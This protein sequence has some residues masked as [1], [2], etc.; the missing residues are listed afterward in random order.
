MQFME[1][2]FFVRRT[3]LNESLFIS[4]PW[5]WRLGAVHYREAKGRRISAC[6]PRGGSICPGLLSRLANTP[7][8]SGW[9]SQRRLLRKEFR[10][11]QFHDLCLASSQTKSRVSTLFQLGLPVGTDLSYR[12][13]GRGGSKWQS[14]RKGPKSASF[15]SSYRQ[16]QEYDLRSTFSS[17]HLW[18]TWSL[19]RGML[20][21]SWSHHLA[22]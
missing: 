12:G 13:C 18:S 9:K 11:R 4:G 3:Y 16:C 21:Y 19:T 20:V 22:S 2:L 8:C 10:S 1:L 6:T 14:R 17:V 7:P 15:S 5:R